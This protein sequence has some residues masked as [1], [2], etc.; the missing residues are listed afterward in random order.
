MCNLL[1]FNILFILYSQQ[2]NDYAIYDGEV[3]YSR[4]G[5]E[6]DGIYAAVVVKDLLR[7]GSYPFYMGQALGTVI[8]SNSNDSQ[9]GSDHFDVAAAVRY[10]SR[11]DMVE[12][13][14]NRQDDV[15]MQHKFAGIYD[16]TVVCAS[17]ELLITDVFVVL[18]VLFVL[19][20]A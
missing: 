18:C 13:F 4:T 12:I 2:Y 9:E 17:P 19:Y 11:R 1:Q 6:A 8:G 10:R 16:T 20:C 5:R 14:Q 15:G 3:N 7:H